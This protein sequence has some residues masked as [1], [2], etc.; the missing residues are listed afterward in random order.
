M[1]LLLGSVI[2]SALFWITGLPFFFI[3]LF[4]PLIPLVFAGI[5]QSD[6]R[7]ACGKP[8]AMNVSFPMMRQS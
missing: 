8:P 1:I 4:V 3:F 6:A 5:S 2:I 7:C